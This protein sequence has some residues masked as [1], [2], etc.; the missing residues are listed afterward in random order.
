[1]KY[2]ETLTMNPA[3]LI[4]Q[5]KALIGTN[6]KYI[7]FYEKNKAN[8]DLQ[9]KLDPLK[10]SEVIKEVASLHFY[11]NAT[12][13]RDSVENGSSKNGIGLNL[14]LFLGMTDYIQNIGEQY[15]EECTGYIMTLIPT[16]YYE[17]VQV[18]SD[19]DSH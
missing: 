5:I 17:I 16:L 7:Q 3:V 9:L 19:S 15:A 12:W 10:T 18:N 6:D 8:R 13:I 1:M 2:T 14:M 11:E 4:L